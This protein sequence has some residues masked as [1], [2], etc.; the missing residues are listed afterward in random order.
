MIIFRLLF[1]SI[2]S[3]CGTMQIANA[4]LITDANDARSWQ[5]ASVGTF[6]QLYFGSNTLANR[7]LVVDNKLLNDSI[8]DPTGYAAATLISGGGGCLGESHDSTGTGS[9]SY[10]CSGSSAAANGNAIDNL[11]FQSDGLV[12][13][14]VFDLGFQASK[15]AI[16]NSIDHGP[17]PQEA[18]ESTVYLSNDQITWVQAV[19]ERVWLEGFEANLGIKWDGFTYAVGTGTDQTFQYASI[20]HGGPGALINDGDDEINGV[21][22]LNS[23]F[24]QVLVSAP[25]A[26]ILLSFGMLGLGFN[27][28]KRI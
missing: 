2:I 23:N 18:I 25:T 15:A 16:F 26:L 6:A 12:G 9:F 17:L 14:T 24:E 5:G 19:V 7:Q 20:I 13:Q 22:G 27:R 1:I 21:L 8:F 10:T 3:V 4:A 28:R 11:W